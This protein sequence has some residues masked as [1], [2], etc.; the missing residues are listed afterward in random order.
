MDEDDIVYAPAGT[1]PVVLVTGGSAG[2]GAAIAR[3][4]AAATVVAAVNSGGGSAAA[5]EAS[6]GHG[7]RVFGPLR[8]LVAL[9]HRGDAAKAGA[10]LAALEGGPAAGHAAFAAELTD[11]AACAALVAEVVARFG[12]IDAIVNNAGVCFDSDVATAMDQAEWRRFWTAT[13]DS[14]FH[15]AARLSLLATRQMLRQQPLAR[16]APSAPSAAA[17]AERGRVV[18]VSSRAAHCGD[19]TAPAY[20]ASKAALNMFTQC[21]AK[22]FARDGVWCFGLAP[23]AT[24]TI[25]WQRLLTTPEQRAAF[26]AR[27]PLG[28]LAQPEEIGEAVAWLA[29]SAP[30]PLTGC[31]V[32]ANGGVHTR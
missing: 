21:M 29:L 14:N 20:A 22:Q 8:P 25:M 1:R 16:P 27:L 6:L 24:D 30:P 32:D 11:P 15:A 28:R 10:V 3:C 7:P 31:V 26:H 4:I 2:I 17:P 18:S 23:G 19:L 9:H 5:A 12:R 13:M